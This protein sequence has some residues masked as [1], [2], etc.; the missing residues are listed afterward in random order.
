MIMK[1]EDIIPRGNIQKVRRNL[2]G[3]PTQEDRDSFTKM[4]EEQ[5]AKDRQ[6]IIL[7]LDFAA[8]V[9]GTIQIHGRLTASF[10]IP[11]SY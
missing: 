10:Q 5:M 1:R 4:Y 3:S 7:F 2:F 6:V 11:R 8:A 9:F